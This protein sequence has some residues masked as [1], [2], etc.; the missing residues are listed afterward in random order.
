MSITWKEFKDAVE[1]NGANNE[2]Q[3]NYIDIDLPKDTDDLEISVHDG[4]LAVT[5]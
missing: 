1:A 3:I 4:E 5:S 2:T